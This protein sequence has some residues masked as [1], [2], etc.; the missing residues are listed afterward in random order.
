MVSVPVVHTMERLQGGAGAA[1]VMAAHP[2]LGNPGL[3][4]GC[5]SHY[6]N[7][8]VRLRILWLYASDIITV[9][10]TYLGKQK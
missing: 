3:R 4:K 8:M 2:G 5:F 10:V 1:F 7:L 6:H 9:S